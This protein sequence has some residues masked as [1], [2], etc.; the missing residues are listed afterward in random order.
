[1]EMR[2]RR[3]ARSFLSSP[4]SR[5]RRLG[6]EVVTVKVGELERSNPSLTHSQA[7][8]TPQA[9]LGEEYAGLRRAALSAELRGDTA[10][11]TL[12]NVPPVMHVAAA[13][14]EGVASY[15]R[16]R[17]AIPWSDAWAMLRLSASADGGVSERGGGGRQ[18][19]PAAPGR[20]TAAEG[21]LAA[22]AAPGAASQGPGCD[23]APLP[24]RILAR[25]RQLSAVVWASVRGLGLRLL[26]LLRRLRAACAPA[27]AALRSAL[28]WLA[29]A[30]AALEHLHLSSVLLAASSGAWAAAWAL[31]LCGIRLVAPVTESGLSPDDSAWASRWR[32]IGL[33]V[34]LRA[35]LELGRVTGA[36]LAAVERHIRALQGAARRRQ[37]PGAVVVAAGGAVEGGEQRAESAPRPAGVD[38]P[39][40]LG[41]AGLERLAAAAA[42]GSDS[43]RYPFPSSESRGGSA[44]LRGSAVI[45]PTRPTASSSV[46]VSI[47]GLV[48]GPPPASA[49]VCALCL[50]PRE[51][52]TVTP[53]GHVFCWACIA[54]AA[55]G[56]PECPVCRQHCLPQELLC[57]H[58]YA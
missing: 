30:A 26:L 46:I 36:A 32:V 8:S 6:C 17:S 5:Q 34:G 40:A 21:P 57:L 54:R 31:R 51:H 20:S 45:T 25:L 13:L 55:F 4:S 42:A 50:N 12:T 33:L 47:A 49:P 10:V 16:A 2:Q 29:A 35:A 48:R 37:G 9:T 43:L 28:P 39:H 7:T 19:P 3:F 15:A 38:E 56:K 44:G 23:P 18:D 24:R 52:P 41:G 53:C 11:V 58:G 22:G 14:L 27:E 1:M